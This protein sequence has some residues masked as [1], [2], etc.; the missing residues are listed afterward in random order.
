MESPLHSITREQ[1]LT[2]PLE[3][4]FAT[5]SDLWKLLVQGQYKFPTDW[6][7]GGLGREKAVMH[8]F[9]WLYSSAMAIHSG[10]II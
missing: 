2:W 1:Q 10:N 5:W 3:L 9:N 7:F 4:F 6:S 8:R